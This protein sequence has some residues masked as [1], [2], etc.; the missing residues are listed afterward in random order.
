MFKSKGKTKQRIGN[1]VGCYGHFI[2]FIFFFLDVL[3][4]TVMLV[5]KLKLQNTLF[6]FFFFFFFF[7]DND[8]QTKTF[9]EHKFVSTSKIPLHPYKTQPHISLSLYNFTSAAFV[10]SFVWF[11]GW[12]TVINCLLLSFITLN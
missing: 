8:A 12:I 10:C 4:I 5:L 1:V 2:F 9:V 3:L 7:F 11:L 6:F